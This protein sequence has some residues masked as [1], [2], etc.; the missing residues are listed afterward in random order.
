MYKQ[1][2]SYISCVEDDYYLGYD[3]YDEDESNDGIII[4]RKAWRKKEREI[5]KLSRS[6]SSR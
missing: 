3:S 5:K 6:L 2:L 1:T 4:D